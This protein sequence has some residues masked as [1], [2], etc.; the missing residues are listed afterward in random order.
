MWIGTHPLPRQCVVDHEEA[1]YE[2]VEV[3]GGEGVARV[4]I[5]PHA[6]LHRDE[7][8]GVEQEESADYELACNEAGD[9]SDRVLVSPGS[10][11]PCMNREDG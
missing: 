4:V 1:V 9:E 7:E 11:S 6:Y 10:E 5:V 8:C 2:D 3:K